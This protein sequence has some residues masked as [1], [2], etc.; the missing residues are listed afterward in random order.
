MTLAEIKKEVFS[1]NQ[2]L[3]FVD[4]QDVRSMPNEA[5]IRWQQDDKETS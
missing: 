2:V 1:N 5:D 3:D 4:Y